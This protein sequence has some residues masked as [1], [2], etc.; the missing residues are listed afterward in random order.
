[1]NFKI[2]YHELKFIL[3]LEVA[4]QNSS[5]TK[6]KENRQK[7]Y[8]VAWI[9][10]KTPAVLDILMLLS[11]LFVLLGMLLSCF[12]NSKKQPKKGHIVSEKATTSVAKSLI[13]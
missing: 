9:T 5:M 8:F 11:L 1:M 4:M 7:L 3:F 12:H 2:L 10:V 6:E 13:V